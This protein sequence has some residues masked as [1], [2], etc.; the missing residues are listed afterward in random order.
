MF[1]SYAFRKIDI[2]Y[3]H[4]CAKASLRVGKVMYAC[5]LFSGFLRL[6]LIHYTM[7]KQKETPGLE[8]GNR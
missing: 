3:M 6:V 5:A 2:G 7:H 8:L 4:S 1:C